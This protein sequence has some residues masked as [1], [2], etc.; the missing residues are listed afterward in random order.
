MN[1]PNVLFFN[2]AWNSVWAPIAPA[3]PHSQQ[4]TPD[5]FDSP[6]TNNIAID[7]FAWPPVDLSKN[8]SDVFPQYWAWRWLYVIRLSVPRPPSEGRTCHSP[9]AMHRL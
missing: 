6:T 2:A 7:I 9:L 3:H 1:T 4:G 8:L 5:A